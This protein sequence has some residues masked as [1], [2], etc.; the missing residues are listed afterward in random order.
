MRKILYICILLLGS[1]NLLAANNS[2]LERALIWQLDSVLGQQDTQNPPVAGTVEAVW[3]YKQTLTFNFV[4]K[5]QQIYYTRTQA[6]ATLHGEYV[7]F[8]V[9]SRF[10][11]DFSRFHVKLVELL[12]IPQDGTPIK[13]I[14]QYKMLSKKQACSR[15]QPA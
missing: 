1:N 14:P 10:E 4:H 11:P 5:R 6:P 2:A 8:K 12:F 9:H 13:L 7:S 15:V 3:Q